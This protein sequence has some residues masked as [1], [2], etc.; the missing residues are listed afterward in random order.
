MA[1]TEHTPGNFRRPLHSIESLFKNFSEIGREVNKEHYVISFGVQVSHDLHTATLEEALRSAWVSLRHESPAI[2]CVVDDELVEYTVLTDASLNQWLEE[3]FLVERSGDAR[4]MV[5]TFVPPHSMVLHYFPATNELLLRSSHWRSDGVGFIS[6]MDRLLSLVITQRKYPLDGSEARN[7]LPPL[8]EVAGFSLPGDATELEAIQ[9]CFTNY[10]PNLPSMGLPVEPQSIS[11]AATRTKEIILPENTTA[12]IIA[13]CKKRG[14]TVSMAIHAAVII[15]LRESPHNLDLQLSRRKY[16]SWTII[17]YRPYLP[18][19]LD[20]TSAH[21][22]AMWLT[23]Y[24]M[25]VSPSG[26]FDEIAEETA[27]NYWGGFPR[28][29]KNHPGKAYN[30]APY[31]HAIANAPSPPPELE[32]IEPALSSLG[33]LEQYLKGSYEDSHRPGEPGSALKVSNPWLGIDILSKIAIV[34]V[35]TWQGKLVLSMCYNAGFYDKASIESY[36]SRTVETLMTELG[37]EA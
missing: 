5:G 15:A 18:K 20:D 34:H 37:V 9:K 21:P 31:F 30:Q 6:L 29:E 35:W 22:A 11:G 27:R 13:A 36:L 24:P 26:T 7:L 2:A 12:A 17:N 33:V 1:W 19:P 10:V 14:H 28:P 32:P 3:S 16:A 25:V 8:E 4:S 23:G